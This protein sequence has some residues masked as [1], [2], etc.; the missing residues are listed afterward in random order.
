MAAIIPTAETAEQQTLSPHDQILHNLVHAGLEKLDGV[1][2][3][4][5]IGYVHQPHFDEPTLFLRRPELPKMSATRAY[6]L[7]ARMDQA[8]RAGAAEA[9][10]TFDDMMVVHVRTPGS[11]SDG[12]HFLGRSEGLFDTRAL[13][14]IRATVRSFAS[15]CNQHVAGL[16]DDLVSPR[17]VVELDGGRT[18]VTAE[19]T[20]PDGEVHTAN[21][22]AADAQEAV[23]RAVLDAAGAPYAFREAR[24]MPVDGTRAVLVVVA[25]SSGVPRPG[26][27]VSDDDLMQATALATL[28]AIIGR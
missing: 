5:L 8:V 4:D 23:A 10:F 12:V 20:T 16:P 13:T 27:V 28:R 1:G 11:R 22:A 15:I 6:R 17:L 9:T 7:F 24:E 26:F 21:A 18:S 3:L 14:I 19:I 25:D 2:P